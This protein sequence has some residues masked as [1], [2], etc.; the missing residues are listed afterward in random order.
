MTAIT[1]SERDQ[2]HL[3]TLARDIAVDSWSTSDLFIP[4]HLAIVETLTYGLTIPFFEYETSLCSVL[5]PSV[6]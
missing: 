1:L 5:H 3:S 4:S 2:W 6:F